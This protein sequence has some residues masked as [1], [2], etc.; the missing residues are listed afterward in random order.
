MGTAPRGTRLVCCRVSVGVKAE[1]AHG[2]DAS[3][4]VLFVCTA[5]RCR[6]PL[7]E[8]FLRSWLADAVGVNISSCGNPDCVGDQPA[9]VDA[10]EAGRRRGVDLSTHRSRPLTS[11]LVDAADLIVAMESTHVGEVA[12]LDQRAWNRTFTLV[13]VVARASLAGRAYP[14]ETVTSYVDRLGEHGGRSSIFD[15]PPGTSIL[16]PSGQGRRAH[17][18]AATLLEA[19]TGELADV[20]AGFVMPVVQRDL[21]TGY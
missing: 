11:D 7:A 17:L 4:S 2:V 16:D 8:A 13:E 20:V 15:W 18:R 21:A 5:N 12:L 9:T 1:G 6:S 19:K 14:D 3:V 10:I